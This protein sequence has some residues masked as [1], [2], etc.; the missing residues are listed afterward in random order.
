MSDEILDVIDEKDQI[1]GQAPKAGVHRQGLRHRVAAVLL[2]G[3]DGKYL[4]PT[5]S[6]IKAE[7]GLLYHSAAGHVL[8]GE[9]YADSARRELKEET[10]LTADDLEYLGAFRFEKE[11]S[12]RI[13]KE[14]F[15][16]YRAIYRPSMGP[17]RLNEE[18][19]NEQWLGER[20]LRA[21]YNRDPQSISAPLLM[22]CKY[23]LGF[24]N[25]RKR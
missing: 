7:A 10:G 24:E 16:V 14:N 11:Y 15:H 20:E 18:Q 12:S 2:Q 5:A 4:I 8:S 3:V 25:E 6:K 22:T 9:S 13:E 17:V 19:V 1:T 23:I 21:I